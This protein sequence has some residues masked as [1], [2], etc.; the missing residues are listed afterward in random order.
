M[1][2]YKL[3]NGC[4]DCGKIIL[5]KEDEFV[6]QDCECFVCSDCVCRPEDYTFCNFCESEAKRTALRHESYLI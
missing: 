5:T 6:C 1:I 4:D 3:L 2:E